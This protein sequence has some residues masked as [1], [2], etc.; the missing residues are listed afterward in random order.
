VFTGDL[1]VQ[2]AVPAARTADAAAEA[3]ADADV[4]VGDFTGQLRVD[5]GLVAAAP[6][7]AF[8][9]QP[10]VGVEAIDLAACAAAGVP[11]ANTAGANAVSVA[12]WCVWGALS[13]LRSA[14]WAD[15]AVRA[16]GWPQLEIAERGCA[17]LAGRR[18]GIVGFGPIGLEA[19]RRFA[20]FGCPVAY[21]SRSRRD[22]AATAGAE[23]MTLD[24]LLATSDVLVVVVALAPETRG[25]LDVDRLSRLPRGAVLVDAARGGV[26]DES[27]LLA[28]LDSGTLAGA[29]LDVFS[30]EPLPE[31]SPLRSDERIVLSP[32]VGGATLQGRL[33]MVAAVTAN[34][35]RAMSGE[36][37]AHVVNG[38]DPVVRR[39]ARP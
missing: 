31:D 20:A 5:A 18:V 1:P 3:A 33:R 12:E 2:I 24:E 39:R 11:V 22:P 13:A 36:P 27:A 35:R 8:V 6:C 10:T 28:L 32:H 29:A 17:E 16:G 25:L 15:R 4:I 14:V 21:W 30:T 37:V 7:L 23:Y 34:L 26:V 9:Q 19:A 38:V